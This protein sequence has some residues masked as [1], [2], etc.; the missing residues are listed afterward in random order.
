MSS[1][2]GVEPMAYGNML[3]VCLHLGITRQSNL[4]PNNVEINRR[5]K[6]VQIHITW[7]SWIPQLDKTEQRI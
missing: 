6:R 2:A 3:L 7:M 5:K 1:L 4:R